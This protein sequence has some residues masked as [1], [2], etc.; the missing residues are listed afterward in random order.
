[1]LGKS[2]KPLSD[3]SFPLHLVILQLRIVGAAP[4]K[5]GCGA[6]GLAVLDGHIVIIAVKIDKHLAATGDKG[7]FIILCMIINIVAVVIGIVQIE[8]ALLID[9]FGIIMGRAVADHAHG[10]AGE[11]QIILAVRQDV[12]VEPGVQ[13]F[14]R[15]LFATT[16]VNGQSGRIGILFGGLLD[17]SVG[18][19][20]QVH[21]ADVVLYSFRGF[22]RRTGNDEVG[23]MA[24]AGVAE[25]QAINLDTGDI[26][27]GF[28]I[29][30]LA[31]RLEEYN[32]G[33]LV[34]HIDDHILNL[35]VGPA[36]TGNLGTRDG[37][38]VQ[39]ANRDQVVAR[40]AGLHHT[41]LEGDIKGGVHIV[42]GLDQDWDKVHKPASVEEK[43]A[44][45]RRELVIQFAEL[46]V[47]D[48]DIFAIAVDIE[49]VD[50][51][52]SEGG[53]VHIV[54]TEDAPLRMADQSQ[55]GSVP[56]VVHHDAITIFLLLRVGAFNP[57]VFHGHIGTVH[58][59]DRLVGIHRAVLR[60]IELDVAH[61]HVV[62]AFHIDAFGLIGGG[63]V[64]ID[65]EIGDGFQV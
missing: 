52:I 27:H 12:I 35:H 58:K 14:D 28:R 56:D 1:M 42:G 48:K 17:L 54:G 53:I 32:L 18:H 26:V 33:D 7:A 20:Q 25:R 47:I 36:L 60:G 6:I 39:L 45:D 16:E 30:N 21:I 38:V 15:I 59:G 63:A 61:P 3:F 64:A 11:S 23:G 49:A 50:V 57:H 55:E 22:D 4:V 10:T 13:D 43:R 37:L 65:L 34:G 46:A 8:R 9:P 51:A 62:I 19:G 24:R 5:Q 41:I 44:E 2:D 40:D 31:G 29:G